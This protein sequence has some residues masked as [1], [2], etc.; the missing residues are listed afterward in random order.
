MGVNVLAGGVQIAGHIAKPGKNVLMS[1]HDDFLGSG[2]F[3]FYLFAVISRH[4]KGRS[5]SPP[6]N[7]ESRTRAIE[8]GSTL[9]NLRFVRAASHSNDAR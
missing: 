7:R 3:P 1:S 8:Y 5:R 4:I 6:D 2:E 9:R